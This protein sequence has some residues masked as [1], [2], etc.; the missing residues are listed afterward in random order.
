MTLL[1]YTFNPT[2][3]K[4]YRDTYHSYDR[5]VHYTFD[6]SRNVCISHHSRQMG[7]MYFQRL[8]KDHIF[9]VRSDGEPKTTKLSDK[10]RLQSIDFTVTCLILWL[11]VYILYYYLEKKKEWSNM[12]NLE[13]KNLKR[14]YLVLQIYNLKRII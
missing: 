2:E 8:R 13:K 14:Y 11:F 4:R 7:L 1:P 3:Q 12:I 6:F 10:R 9:C 5:F